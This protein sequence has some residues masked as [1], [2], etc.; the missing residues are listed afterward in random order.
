[1]NNRRKVADVL[2]KPDSKLMRFAEWT[3]KLI[4]VQ[5]IWIL[6]SLM[7]LFFLGIF[8]A[9]FTMFGVIRK[10]IMKQDDFPV[11]K[12]FWRTYKD[13]FLKS[14]LLGYGMLLLGSSIYY[15]I[16]M[17]SSM[18]VVLFIVSMMFGLVFLMTA[19]FIIPVYVHFDIPLPEVIRHAS[20]IAVSHPLHILLMVLSLVGFWF[21]STLLPAALPFIGFS[22]ICYLLMLIA[23]SAFI[24]IE[25]KVVNQKL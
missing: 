12:T 15:Y 3:T 4:H 11:F 7:G 13:M 19:L 20:I 10:W 1:M 18:S 16:D 21:F 5:I 8:P 9:T 14:N 24:S 22:L 6:F 25:K 23:Y 17:F 2:F